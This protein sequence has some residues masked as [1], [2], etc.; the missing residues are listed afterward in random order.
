MGRRML[1]YKW[2]VMGQGPMGCLSKDSNRLKLHQV[3]KVSSKKNYRKK[4][5]ENEDSKI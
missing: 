4:N 5:Q 2:G 3:F 1:L